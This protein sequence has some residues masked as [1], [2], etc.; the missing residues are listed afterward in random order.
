[1]SRVL[2]RKDGKTVDV[3]DRQAFYFDPIEVISQ[4][5]TTVT[6]TATAIP[7]SNLDYRKTILIKN[8]G[9]NTVY[10]GDSSVTTADGYPLEAGEEKSFDIGTDCTLYGITGSSTSEVRTIEGGN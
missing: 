3:Q 6:T 1:M 7:S 4:N 5:T 10:L 8:I 9:S 2:V